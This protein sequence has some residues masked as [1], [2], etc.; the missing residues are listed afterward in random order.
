[1]ASDKMGTMS[2][3]RYDPKE[4]YDDYKENLKIYN[5]LKDLEQYGG[6]KKKK[7]MME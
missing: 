2:R 5:Y 6:R 4:T 7:S 1:M 3:S